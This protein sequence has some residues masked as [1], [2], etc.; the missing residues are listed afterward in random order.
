MSHL[1]GLWHAQALLR[2]GHEAVYGRA[3]LADVVRKE[4]HGPAAEAVAAAEGA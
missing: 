1:C 4:A 2:V 3:Q